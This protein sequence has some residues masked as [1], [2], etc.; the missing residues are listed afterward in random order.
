MKFT[1]FRMGLY[2]HDTNPNINSTSE[3]VSRY[4]FV[5]TEA[6]NKDWYHHH[7]I[8]GADHAK[9]LYTMIRCPLQ[10]QFE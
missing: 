1:E 7:K 2:Y 8:D 6:G 3:C 9:S 10:Q 4:S 5:I